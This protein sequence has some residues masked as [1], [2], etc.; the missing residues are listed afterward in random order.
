MVRLHKQ[1]ARDNRKPGTLSVNW[2]GGHNGTVTLS[3]ALGKTTRFVIP[4]DYETK[5]HHHRTV[6]GANQATLKIEA[7]IPIA[8]GSSELCG[9]GNANGKATTSRHQRFLRGRPGVRQ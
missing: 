9:E 8:A 7:S 5:N 3:G 6:T 1:L 4:W 2:T